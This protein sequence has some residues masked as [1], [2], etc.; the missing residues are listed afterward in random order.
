M[1]LP[2]IVFLVVYIGGVVLARSMAL[3]RG[4]NPLLWGAC[5]VLFSPL[6][7][8]P[9]LFFFPRADP[10]LAGTPLSQA[11]LGGD[12]S[13]SDGKQKKLMVGAI[14]LLLVGYSVFATSESAITSEFEKLLA[15][16]DL[17]QFKVVDTRISPV[18]IFGG[19]NDVDIFVEGAGGEV[20][21]LGAI[22]IGSPIFEYYLEIPGAELLKIRF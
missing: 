5:T 6:L 14:C 16:N 9:V 8:L 4:Q 13:S 19:R 7:S 21:R 12:T 17:G 18:V 10:A 1:G 3:K 20:T 11:S 2:T 22:V 15:D